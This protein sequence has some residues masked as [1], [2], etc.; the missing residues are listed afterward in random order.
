MLDSP[1]DRRKCP[2]FCNASP[3]VG[4]YVAG[5]GDPMHELGGAGRV[6]RASSMLISFTSACPACLT[7]PPTLSIELNPTI[8]WHQSIGDRVKQGHHEV[9][10]EGQGQRWADVILLIIRG[11]CNDLSGFHPNPFPSS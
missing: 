8:P 3:D 4:F 2:F 7:L 9:C 11:S 10:V 6:R 1:R 5:T